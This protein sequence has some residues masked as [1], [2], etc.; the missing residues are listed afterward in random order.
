MTFI[1]FY[2]QYLNI[3]GRQS[4]EFHEMEMVKYATIFFVVV[5]FI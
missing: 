1:V 2:F 4:A 3:S 5:A